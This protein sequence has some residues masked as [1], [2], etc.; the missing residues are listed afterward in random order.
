MAEAKKSTAKKATATK[1]TT[2]A[3]SQPKAQAATEAEPVR[4]KRTFGRH[5]LTRNER[6]RKM[7]HFP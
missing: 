4:A 6:R 3:A 1:A 5:K 2:K 7:S